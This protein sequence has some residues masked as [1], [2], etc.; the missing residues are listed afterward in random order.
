MHFVG[1]VV[2]GGGVFSVVVD[3]VFIVIGDVLLCLIL[4]F[5]VPTIPL[6]AFVV[7]IRKEVKR[8]N[9]RRCISRPGELPRLVFLIPSCYFDH[10]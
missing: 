1:V 9:H 3:V 6:S 5:H 8:R 7:V 10:R 4:I 2:G